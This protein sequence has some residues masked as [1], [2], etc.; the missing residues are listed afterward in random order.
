MILPS[1]PKQI[2]V[3]G[4]YGFHNA[5]DEAILAALC[6]LFTPYQIQMKV[7]TATP[8]HHLEGCDFEPVPRLKIPQIIQTMRQSDLFISGGGGLF[9]DVTGLGSV[10]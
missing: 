7:L 5:G 8:D 9:Q 1:P 6:Q 2:L 10:P 3:S 4:Y